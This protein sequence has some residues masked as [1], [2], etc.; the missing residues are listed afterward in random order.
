MFSFSFSANI[1]FLFQ[2][3]FISL[4]ILCHLHYPGND[5]NV[6]LSNMQNVLHAH[7]V[8]HGVH[9]QTRHFNQHWNSTEL[10]NFNFCSVHCVEYAIAK[11]V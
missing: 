1:M 8:E 2:L 9:M 7:D 10:W 3:L 6:R 11:I 4:C 5:E